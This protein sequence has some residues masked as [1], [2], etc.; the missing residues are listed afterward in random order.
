MYNKLAIILMDTIE[1][2]FPLKSVELCQVALVVTLAI[3][4]HVVFNLWPTTIS[5]QALKS[6]KGKQGYYPLA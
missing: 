4:L 6:N 3:K 2:F 1:E 5:K